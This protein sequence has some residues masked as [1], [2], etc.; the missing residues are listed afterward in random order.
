MIKVDPEPRTFIGQRAITAGFGSLLFAD[1]RTV[2]QVRD[3]ALSVRAE[4]RGTMGCSGGR[5]GGFHFTLTS[6]ADKDF[7]RYCDD[8]VVAI[9]L[10]KKSL[11][12]KLEDVLNID[13]VDMVQY[14]PC[15]YAMTAGV[16]GQYK[17]SKVVETDR[18]IIKMALKYDKHPRIEVGGDTVEKQIKE[19]QKL[20][21][22]DFAVGTDVGIVNSWI[23]DNGLTARKLLG[24]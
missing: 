23:R 13:D 20:G 22:T 10:E 7:V 18:K 1:L 24:R 12:D 21:V 19:Y 3:A 16:H 9:M 4:P 6:G 8:L 14:G 11:I 2:E 15:D 5:I 17:H